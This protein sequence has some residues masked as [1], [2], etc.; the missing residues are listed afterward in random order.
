MRVTLCNFWT[1]P[2]LN[3]NCNSVRKVS[4]QLAEIEVINIA[5]YSGCGPSFR[6]GFGARIRSSAKFR[7]GFRIQNRVKNF[8]VLVCNSE[9]NFYACVFEI[10][11]RNSR[12]E[13]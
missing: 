7:F 9:L 13:F 1:A 6:L 10:P 12:L 2:Y 8:R 11:I 3:Q 4:M 5:Q